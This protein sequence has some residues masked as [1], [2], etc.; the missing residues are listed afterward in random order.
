MGSKEHTQKHYRNRRERKLAKKRERRWEKVPTFSSQEGQR[1]A[2][3]AAQK[4]VAAALSQASQSVRMTAPLLRSHIFLQSVDQTNDKKT[5]RH[6]N[7]TRLRKYSSNT[8]THINQEEEEWESRNRNKTPPTHQSIT[9]LLFFPFVFSAT[10]DCYFPA[11]LCLWCGWGMLSLFGVFYVSCFDF[12]YIF[13][14]FFY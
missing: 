1:A 14:F 2:S 3:S 11:L 6:W 5:N 12:D 8:Q 10:P 13:G 7:K 4:T 9:S